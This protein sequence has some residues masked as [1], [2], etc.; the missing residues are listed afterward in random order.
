MTP[1]TFDDEGL[2]LLNEDAIECGAEVMDLPMKTR[3][4][5][6]SVVRF[7]K[8]CTCDSNIHEK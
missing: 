2:A 4:D 6:E 8:Y 7:D 1:Q 5:F 3:T